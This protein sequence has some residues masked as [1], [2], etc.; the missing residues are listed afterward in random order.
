[1]DSVLDQICDKLEN[2]ICW[3]AGDDEY[4]QL[5]RSH[6]TSYSDMPSY[7]YYLITERY[8]RYIDNIGYWGE[9]EYLKIKIEKFLTSSNNQEKYSLSQE[10]DGELIKFIDGFNDPRFIQATANLK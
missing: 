4:Y 9:Y 2:T 6:L 3:E 7:K 1:M 8:Q 10:I 5:I